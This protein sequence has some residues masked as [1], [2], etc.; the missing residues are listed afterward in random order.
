MTGGRSRGN[1]RSRAE[2]LYIEERLRELMYSEDPRYTE[3]Q[4]LAILQI[5]KRTFDRYKA[6]I[7]KE[8]DAKRKKERLEEMKKKIGGLYTLENILRM[9]GRGRRRSKTH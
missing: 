8:I 6:R 5:P 9:Y 3:Q 1:K 4:Q 7:Q 2:I